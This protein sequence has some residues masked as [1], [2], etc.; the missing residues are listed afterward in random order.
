MNRILTVVGRD[1]SISSV[2]Q[3]T[4]ALMSDACNSSPSL[5]R[6][7][8][9]AIV[10]SASRPRIMFATLAAPPSRTSSDSCRSRMTGASWL[11]RSASPQT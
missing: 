10:T 11:T 5:S 6:P 9:P 8:T 2:E 1:S 7:T 3:S 4:P